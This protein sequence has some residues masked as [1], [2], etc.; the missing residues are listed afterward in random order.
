[1]APRSEDPKLIIRV[2]NLELVQSIWPQYVNI[3]DGQT[4]GRRTI[5]I[6]CL[7]YMHRAVKKT[8]H[9]FYN[10]TVNTDIIVLTFSLILSLTS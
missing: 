7:H 5:A 2:I 9:T 6:P 4:D 3:T 10:K 8:R 1:M